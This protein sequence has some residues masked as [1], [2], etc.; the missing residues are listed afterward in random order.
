MVNT[1]TKMDN[2]IRCEMTIIKI[3]S[4]IT[5]IRT[6]MSSTIILTGRM[7]TMA[8]NKSKTLSVYRLGWRGLMIANKLTA[9]LETRV[10]PRKEGR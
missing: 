2:K 10:L 4:S 5:M 8:K 6:S 1:M 9:I 7:I 3:S